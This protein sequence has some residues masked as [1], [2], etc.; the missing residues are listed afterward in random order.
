ML[1]L[2]W[3]QVRTRRL[4]RSHLV[5]R[6]PHDRVLDVVGEVC[7]IQAQVM[8][9]SEFAIGARVEGLT[10][11]LI[12]SEL[13]ERRS[14]VKTYGPRGTLHVLPA[15]ELP[16]WMA[17]MRA[18]PNHQGAMWYAVPGLGRAQVDALVAATRDAL[19]GR[20][21]TREKLASEVAAR[22]GSWA[23]ERLQSTW[24]ECLG[25]AAI[26][27][28]LCFGPSRG[29][30]VT[31][32]R[33]DQ[34][35]GGWHDEDPHAAILQVVRRFLS[36]YGPARPQ[37]FARWFV[38]KP[39]TAATLFSELADEL[40]AVEVEG[41]VA[42]M[43]AS[44]SNENI[45]ESRD[46]V[47]LVAQYDSFVFGSRPREQLMTEDAHKRIRSYRRGRFEGAVA[48]S[49]VLVDGRVAGIWERR[50]L[51]RRVEVAVEPIIALTPR[52]LKNLDAEVARVGKFYGR[53][54]SLAIGPLK[55]T[56]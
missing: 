11:K 17:A 30:N 39:A 14:L 10:P 9:A 4:A 32:A 43:T 8:S 56:G 3:D 28:A 38:T 1:T 50:V 31:F 6:A 21:L 23:Q 45:E 2:T 46:L 41:Q 36:A 44:D 42:W 27:G 20:Q 47:N 51:V 37:E 22:A 12:R 13:W 5:H 26:S 35:I 48:L 24:G 18:I 29:T 34:W 40:V 7:G 55:E 15:R 33:A 19:D 52:Q 53:E 25:P 54:A 16:M 49:T